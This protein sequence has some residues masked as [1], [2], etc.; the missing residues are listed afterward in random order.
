MRLSLLRRALLLAMTLAPAAL[1]EPP[2]SS[3][4]PPPSPELLVKRPLPA[5]PK[6][7]HPRVVLRDAGNQPVAVSGGWVS[8]P[9]TCGQCHDTAWIAQHG[10]HFR[11]G[12]DEQTAPRQS[13]SGRTWD[14]GSGLF[15]RWDP[16]AGY[17]SVLETAERKGPAV[18]HWVRQNLARL[19]GG[20]PALLGQQSRGF[21]ANCALCHV[22]G[23][24]LSTDPELPL[25]AH[26]TASL[27]PLGL[28]RISSDGHGVAKPIWRAAAFAQDGSVDPASLLVQAPSSAAC[29]ACHGVAGRTEPKLSDWGPK[30]RQTETTGQLYLPTRISDSALNL[31]GRSALTR[32]WDVHAERLLECADCHFSPNDP[33]AAFRAGAQQPEHLRHEVRHLPFGEYLRRPSHELAKGHSTQSHVS[34]AHDGTMRRC[35]DCHDAQRVHAWLPKKERHLEQVGCETCHIP[36]VHAPSRRVT[37]Y[38]VIDAEGHPRVEYR[39]I[40]GRMDDPAAYLP[41]Y[42]PVLLRRVDAAGRTR[43][44]PYNVIT[45]YFWVVD[46]PE[47]T[48]PASVALL[49]R[50]LYE[51]P[52]SQERLSAALDQ[53]RDGKVQDEERVLATASAVAAVTELLLGAG[54]R[55]PR[56]VGELQPYGIHHGVGPAR[57]ALRDCDACHSRASRIAQPVELA[58]HAPFGV[59]P[60]LLS[61][62]NVMSSFTVQ[63]S[64][65][66]RLMLVP[67]VERTGLHVFGHSRRGWLDLLGMIALGLVSAGAL[68][69][70]VLRA[71]ARRQRRGRSA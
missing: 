63:P 42:R 6:G 8:F 22:P 33:S 38:T 66:G 64:G 70:G 34:D 24:T 53:N 18:D 1:G 39:G 10:Y 71:W 16:L 62:S 60:T 17:D 30:A 7:M 9:E 44:L 49:R 47:G 5:R 61:D 32:P 29:G 59:T 50:A 25:L 58:E 55:N 20:G 52:T 2:A 12:V 65:N 26:Q 43:V 11:V 23:A 69:H 51:L 68:G 28:V 37:D 57:F 41:E 54:A 14:F 45:S 31:A 3:A 67:E 35:E 21:E 56:I 4:L 27:L 15:G 46:T 40:A 36:T 19:V 48:R 13:R